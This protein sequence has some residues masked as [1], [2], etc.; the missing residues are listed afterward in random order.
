MKK[1]FQI[2]AATLISVVI[3]SCSKQGVV[4]PEAAQKASEE[5]STSSSSPN[6]GF[7]LD[8]LLVSL[9]GSFQFNNDLKDQ[10]RKLSDGVPSAQGLADTSDR[11]G[12][13]NSAIYLNGNYGI[14]IQKVPQQT[15]TSLSVWIKPSAVYNNDGLAYIAKPSAYGPVMNHLSNLLSGGVVM[16]STVPGCTAYFNNSGWRHL[17][18]TY[19][20]TDVKFY[21]N[22]LLV[23]THNKPGYIPASVSDYYIG[24]VLGFIRWKGKIDD[25]RFYSRALSATDVQKLYNL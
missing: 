15:N 13:L 6:G 3:V 16:N 7:V 23:Q 22:G 1:Q 5:I 21:V 2:F 25:L 24:D 8:P 17:A 18:V 14:K 20:G 12:K 4:D 19:N 11:K 10:T 9:E